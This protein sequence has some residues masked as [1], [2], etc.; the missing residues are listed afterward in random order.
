MLSDIFT[1]NL[2]ANTKPL[3]VIFEDRWTGGKLKNDQSK[4]VTARSFSRGAPLLAKVMLFENYPN[5]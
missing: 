2:E 5:K 3:F 4:S 1:S